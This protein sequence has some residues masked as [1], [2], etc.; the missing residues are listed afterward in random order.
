MK[1]FIRLDFRATAF[2]G[3]FSQFFYGWASLSSKFI[4]KPLSYLPTL[5]KH[6]YTL[7]CKT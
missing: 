3:R 5:L 2:V 1:L 4:T 6:V 7:P